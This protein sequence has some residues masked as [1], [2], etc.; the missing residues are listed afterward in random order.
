MGLDQA[1]PTP[2]GGET[3]T[4][5]LQ[6]TTLDDNRLQVTLLYSILIGFES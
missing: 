3:R 5:L 1:T 2:P 4:T 6:G